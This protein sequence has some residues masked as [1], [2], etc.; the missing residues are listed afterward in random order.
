MR[1]WF[2]CGFLVLALS[3]A[4]STA[5]LA[6][7]GIQSATS[8]VGNN[9]TLAVDQNN[10]DKLNVT[11]AGAS[12]GSEYVVF[13]TS[14]GAS[15]T[16]TESNL[17]YIDQKTAGSGGV[18]FVVY[19]KTLT[20][21]T[22]QVWMSSNAASGVGAQRAVN[23]GN[24]EYYTEKPAYTLGDVNT[25]GK[26]NSVDALYVLRKYA[27]DTT[28]TLTEAQLLAA[29]VDGRNGVNSVDALYILR[30]YAGDITTFPA[31]T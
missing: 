8:V 3:L 29:D 19:P 20:S 9:V 30:F 4:M 15:E 2:V 18:S 10:P 5:A 22:Y 7:D 27:G 21:G 13:A 16:P 12:A 11:Y 17:V 26:I 6:A 24:F 28:L 14:G 23:I 1:K 31:G 25:D